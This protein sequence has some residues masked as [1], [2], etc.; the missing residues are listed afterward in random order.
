M[1][2]R[3]A[4]IVLSLAT[5]TRAQAPAQAPA[6][7]SFA[8]T[9]YSTADPATF[10]PKALAQQRILNPYTRYQMPLP[11]YGVVRETRAIDLVAGENNVRFTDVASGID[12]TTV[13]FRS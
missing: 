3:A 7:G 4:L 13:A 9:V 2:R 5:I 6:A 10:D 1:I 8:L 12:P 11:G